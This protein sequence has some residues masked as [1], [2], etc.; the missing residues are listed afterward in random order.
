MDG[1][2]F[3][4]ANKVKVEWLCTEELSRRYGEPGDGAAVIHADGFQLVLVGTPEELGGVG[5]LLGMAGREIDEHG[6][7]MTNEK[8]AE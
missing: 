2:W 8:E 3:A 1:L 7:D 6:R 4:D 5:L